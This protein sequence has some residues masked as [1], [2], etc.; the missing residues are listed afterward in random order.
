VCPYNA[1]TLDWPILP[2]FSDPHLPFTQISVEQ[3]AQMTKTQYE[4]WFGGTAATRAKFDGLV[5]NALLHLSAIRH[6]NLKPICYNALKNDSK[7]I[8]QTVRQILE[9]LNSSS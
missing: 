2:E 8:R 4:Q 1:V 9:N 3:I 7:L 6:V 5:R